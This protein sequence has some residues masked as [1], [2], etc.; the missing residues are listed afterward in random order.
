M[1]REKAPRARVIPTLA[2]ERAPTL[3]CCG[4]TFSEVSKLAQH[5]DEVHTEGSS[6]GCG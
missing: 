4:E 3:H 2:S 6:C 5:L 1:T